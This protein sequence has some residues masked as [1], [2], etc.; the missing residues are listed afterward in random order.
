LIERLAL[1]IPHLAALQRQFPGTT[2]KLA[3]L[4]S[5]TIVERLAEFQLDYGVVRPEI[6][7]GRMASAPLGKVEYRLLVTKP[8]GGRQRDP[9]AL[10]LL[11]KLS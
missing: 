6:L 4:R 5:T 10:T 2:I 9:D 1:L 7:G 11:G 8:L 3:N